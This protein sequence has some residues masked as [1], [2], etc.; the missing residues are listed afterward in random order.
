MTVPRPRRSHLLSPTYVTLDSFE[1]GPAAYRQ[2]WSLPV[3]LPPD[4]P[5]ALLSSSPS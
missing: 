2:A 1:A 4:S 3:A 5:A